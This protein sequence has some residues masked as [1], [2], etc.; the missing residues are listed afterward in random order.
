MSFLLSGEDGD[1]DSDGNGDWL[2]WRSQGRR[3]RQSDGVRQLW[4]ALH[5]LR[6]LVG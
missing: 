6:S 3:A 4:E 5:G 2:Q 1:D